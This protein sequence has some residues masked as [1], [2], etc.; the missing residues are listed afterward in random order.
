MNYRI[1]DQRTADSELLPEP[2]RLLV[3][4]AILQAQRL[5]RDVKDHLVDVL[6]VEEV[7]DQELK[8]QTWLRI[9]E[10]KI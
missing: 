1:A 5:T 4:W 7:E 9:E 2:P 8:L 3:L 6:V 10:S